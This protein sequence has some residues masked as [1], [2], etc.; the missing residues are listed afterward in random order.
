MRQ[1]DVV[2]LDYREVGHGFA[3]HGFAFTFGP[4]PH[5]RLGNLIRGV[6]QQR[7]RDQVPKRL[8][9]VSARQ[10]AGL[11]RE[12]TKNIPVA[13]RFPAGRHRLTQWMKVGVQIGG[14]EVIL[15]VPA[16]RRQNDIGVERRCVHTEVQID[17]QIHLALCRAF[18]PLNLLHG[19]LSGFVG[20]RIGVRAQ[21]VA[22]EILV[23]L[24]AAME[25]IGP[26]DQPHTRPVFG[27]IG[28]FE[29]E[30]RFTGAKLFHQPA[31]NF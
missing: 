5:L 13:A 15:L 8:W 9:K 18:P 30:A 23:S 29:R 16:C 24:G 2:A 6:V 3:R 11:F 1:V 26:P 28:F 14:V 7:R 10:F 21:I 19:L 4:I 27:Q 22:Q 20:D 31:L 12:S 17:N 25:R